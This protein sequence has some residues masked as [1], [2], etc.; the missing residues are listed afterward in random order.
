MASRGTAQ[1]R[2]SGEPAIPLALCGLQTRPLLALSLSVRSGSGPGPELRSALVF[3]SGPLQFCH[4]LTT[5]HYLQSFPFPN[6][7]AF[8]LKHTDVMTISENT[9]QNTVMPI[10]R[11][12]A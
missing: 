11:K 5:S 7:N 1:S 9:R 10:I 3:L 12:I 6:V 4:I 2:E 8:N